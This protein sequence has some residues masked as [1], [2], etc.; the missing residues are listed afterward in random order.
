[1]T[2]SGYRILDEIEP[3][4]D[5]SWALHP[6]LAFYGSM[7]ID[8]PYLAAIGVANSFL[9]GHPRRKH[10]LAV[11]VAAVM[12][13]YAIDFVAF[14]F[15]GPVLRKYVWLF[16]VGIHLWLGYYLTEEH[17]W[18]S[19]MFEHAGGKVVSFWSTLMLLQALSRILVL[20]LQQRAARMFIGLV[21]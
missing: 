20:R 15:F 19:E 4:T 11:G 8:T 5:R 7:M 21:R 2:T 13:V 18:A 16:S 10:H 14:T 17:E 6:Q 3:V 12:G 9:L 1:M